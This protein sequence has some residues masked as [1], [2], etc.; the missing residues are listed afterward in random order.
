[1]L[2]KLAGASASAARVVPPVPARFASK[3]KEIK[4]QD[5]A[6]AGMLRGVNL[7]AKTVAVTLGPRGR[8]VVMDQAYGAP[9]ITKDGVTVAK[10]IEFADKFENMG[11]QLVRQAASTTNDVAGDGTTTAT[12]LAQAIAVEGNR[13]VSTG[14]NPIELKRGI[15][16]A[17]KNV[18]ANLM[19]QSRTLKS[20][21]E[22]AQ[23][24]VISANGDKEVGDLIASAMEKVGTNGVITTEDGKT[25]DTEL[26]VVEGMSL[27]RGFAS[28]Y[29]INNAKQQKCE[30]ENAF[31]LVS[32]NKLS[33]IHELLPVLNY[34][35]RANRPLLIVAD[36][37]EGDALTTLI[38]N[39][40]AG[41]LNVCAIK[42]PGFGDH[43]TNLLHD[44]ATYTG[45]TVLSNES[46]TVLD[47]KD[48]KFDPQILGTCS[49]VSISKDNSVFLG[50]GGDAGRISER[51]ELIQELITKTDSEYDREKLKE[52]L[53]KLSGGVAVIKVGGASDVEVGEKKDR[54][55]DAL[56]ATR[57]AVAEGIVAG[58][59]LSLLY[60]SLSLKPILERKDLAQDQ[61]TGVKILA[62]A[63]RKPATIICQNAG[64]E[65][66]VMVH[67]MIEG[68]SATHG[69]DAA[70]GQWC[71]FFEKGILD[72][73]LVVKTALVN[74]AS[75]ASMMLTTEAA[76]ADLPEGKSDG[77]VGGAHANPAV[78]NMN[79]YNEMF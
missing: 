6:R 20:T 43:K 7:L 64:V 52:R 33:S 32:L 28:P 63:I 77:T 44:L 16:L 18:V 30:Y 25:L 57:A 2:S 21:E 13:A 15:D 35:V 49:K 27:D 39:K 73:V 11:A 61:L 53:A 66:G 68:A 1:M 58:A 31:V 54:V 34:V 70:T 41:K 78:G 23:V 8:N 59:G 75:V 71:D 5:D 55:V 29:F 10:S 56:N 36:D 74:A 4:F 46:G 9:K 12:V 3:G 69:Y 72:P 51:T 67:K 50:G 17:V 37:I 40:A 19:E 60:A 22:I 26:H 45:S 62:Q 65:G 38:L 48:D 42:A 76:V 79:P 47:P 14:A 24:A